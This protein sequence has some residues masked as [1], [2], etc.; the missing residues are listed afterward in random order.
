MRRC[1]A[2]RGAGPLVQRRPPPVPP[3]LAVNAAGSM[4]AATKAHPDRQAGGEQRL[5]R[6]VGRAAHQ[7]HRFEEDEIR[8]LLLEDAGQKPDGVAPIGGVCI[9]V[10]A[11]RNHHVLA[12]PGVNGSLPGESHPGASD[13]H[14]MHRAG[15]VPHLRALCAQ[16]R[17]DGPGVGGDDVAANVHIASMEVPHAIGRVKD[18]GDAPE[19][20]FGLGPMTHNIDQFRAGR[21]VE[22]HA[23]VAREQRLDPR[24][25]PRVS[26]RTHQVVPV[27]PRGGRCLSP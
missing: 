4:A 19:V 15:R 9:S 24:V 12:S 21:A 14:P 3:V 27:L 11:E 18:R 23:C 8:R 1:R 17:G 22:Q 13:I 26:G 10:D 25:S 7:R 2:P 20:L 6:R 16:G 5:H